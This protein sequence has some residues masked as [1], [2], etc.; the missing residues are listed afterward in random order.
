MVL[1]PPSSPSSA[2]TGPEAD[3]PHERP[4]RRGRRRLV[5]ATIVTVAVAGVVSAGGWIASSAD[6]TPAV[7]SAHALPKLT[8]QSL[9]RARRELQVFGL[10]IGHLSAGSC[11]GTTSAP[12]TVCSQY[13][14]AGTVVQRGA[15][16]D[17]SVSH[18]SGIAAGGGAP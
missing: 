3:D 14:P 10:R 5:V 12:R 2:P 7:G 8:G 15:E 17:L 13:P 16:V 11:A 4:R 1:L 6:P 9:A 18:P